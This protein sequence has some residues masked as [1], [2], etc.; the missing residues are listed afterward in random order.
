MTR[1]RGNIHDKMFRARFAAPE[2]AGLLFSE[3]LPAHIFGLFEPGPPELITGSFVDDEL[4]EHCTDLLYGARLKRG[5]WAYVY[6]LVEHKSDP[7]PETP[8]QLLRYKANIW[9]RPPKGG[10]KLPLTPIIPLGVYHGARPWK[11]ATT[12]HDLF[13]ALDDEVRPLNAGF[14]Y[15]LIDLG[16]IDD[17]KLSC[18]P[19]PKLQRATACSSPCECCRRP[20]SSSPAPIIDQGNRQLAEQ[21]SVRWLKSSCSFLPYMVS[22]NSGTV[23]L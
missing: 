17:E 7:D 22:P 3:H 13:R 10:A 20:C 6:V 1:K 21:V 11:V 15:I 2:A 16:Q 14:D 18:P 4:A 8:V 19:S 12:F 5:G 23:S 9:S